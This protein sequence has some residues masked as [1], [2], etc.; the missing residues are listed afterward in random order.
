LVNLNLILMN[1]KVI[2]WAVITALGGFLFGFDTVVVSGAEQAIQKYWQLGDFQ[3]GFTIAIA[4]VGTMMGAFLGR[5][6]AD[7]LG[8][9]RALMIVAV[10]FLVT[11]LGTA[12]VSNWYLFVI[13]RFIGGLGIG[14]SSVIAPI[15]I[16]E[17]SPASFR[18]RLVILF[19]FNIVLGIVI[20]LLSNYII[21]TSY[22]GSW[23]L[24]LAVMAVPSLLYLILLRFVPESPRWLILHKG[25]NDEAEKTLQVINPDNYQQEMESIVNSKNQEVKDST[26]ENLFT[27]RY[28]RLA[29]LAF[30]IA[31]FNQVSGINA[32]LYYA[33]SIFTMAGFDKNNSFSASFYLGLVNF[34]FTMLAIFLIDRMGRRKLMLIGSFGLIA[35]LGLVSYCFHL[36]NADGHYVIWLLMAYIAFF[37]VSQGAVIWVFLSEIFP[38]QVRAKGQSL[39]SFTH[40]T[41]ATVIT[42]LFPAIRT[43]VDGQY[44]FLFFCVMMFLQLLFVWKLMPETKGKSLENM[45]RTLTMH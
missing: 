21:V 9:K 38:N 23:R 22:H 13:M 15:Y 27:K 4:L 41:L 10:I 30:L 2:F 32:I 25:R 18:G 7:Q 28:R 1:K 29:W 35:S 8:R 3:H 11:S 12:V 33:P 20:S 31:F 26:S 39:G 6:P 19:Q 14:A 40:W 36:K 44:I 34:A 42:F 37:A 5:M 24:M 43:H 17:I 45:E 16:S